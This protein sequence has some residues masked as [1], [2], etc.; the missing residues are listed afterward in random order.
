MR[1]TLTK[2]GGFG[3]GLRRPATAVD[4]ASLS[5]GEMAELSSLLDAAR[6]VPAPAEDGPGLVRDGMTY[7]VRVEGG[8]QPVTLSGSDGALA[9]PFVALLEWLDRRAGER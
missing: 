4:A 1:I 3:V 6:A 8:P 9:P 7:T 5:T 2:E